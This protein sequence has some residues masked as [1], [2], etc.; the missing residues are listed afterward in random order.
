MNFSHAAKALVRNFC[1]DVFETTQGLMVNEVNYTMEYKNSI[2]T[3]GVNIPQKMVEYI[4]QVAEGR[5]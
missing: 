2:A 3:T 1:K 4:L 5:K